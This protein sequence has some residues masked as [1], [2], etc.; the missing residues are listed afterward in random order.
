[1]PPSG[2]RGGEGGTPPRSAPYEE[3]DRGEDHAEGE[4]RRAQPRA[5]GAQGRE[6]QDAVQGQ[7]AGAGE[8]EGCLLYT[9]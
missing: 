1:M 7:P 5:G 6:R 9:S 8:G 2:R 4:G 3:G